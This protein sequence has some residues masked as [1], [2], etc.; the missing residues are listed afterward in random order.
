MTTN[1]AVTSLRDDLRAAVKRTMRERNRKALAVFRSALAAIDNAEA[2]PINPSGHA[3]AM[4][5]SSG[6]GRTEVQRHL[7]SEQDVIDVVRREVLE[8]REAAAGPAGANADAARQLCEEVDALQ[9]MVDIAA[10]RLAE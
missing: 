9:N 10:S 2:V 8:R 6:L 3:G 1:D 7:L 5:Q 4:E